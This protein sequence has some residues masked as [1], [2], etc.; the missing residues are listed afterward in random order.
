M[1]V[2]ADHGADTQ[3]VMDNGE[4]P[5]M[6]ATGVIGAL[7]FYALTQAYRLAPSSVVAPVTSTE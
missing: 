4:T 7:G 2:L 6:A 1:R 3:N 5:L